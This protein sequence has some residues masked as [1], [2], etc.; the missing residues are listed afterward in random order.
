VIGSTVLLFVVCR[1]VAC[2]QSDGSNTLLY[3][4]LL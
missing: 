2:K 3:G 4:G 1:P